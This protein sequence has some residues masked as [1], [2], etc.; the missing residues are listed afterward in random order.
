MNAEGAADRVEIR[1]FSA[2][3]TQ[4]IDSYDVE[5]CLATLTDDRLL[6][7]AERTEA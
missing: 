1:E 3:Y 7:K 6:P 2:K 4:A 5:A